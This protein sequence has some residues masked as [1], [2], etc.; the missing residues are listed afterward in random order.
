MRIVCFPNS[1][2]VYSPNRP[3]ERGFVCPEGYSKAILD[4]LPKRA[5]KTAGEQ[6]SSHEIMK[7]FLH[8]LKLVWIVT[9]MFCMIFWTANEK[10]DPMLL[11]HSEHSCTS[12]HVG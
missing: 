6:M 11:P 12:Q 2:V 7:Q 1:A 3:N 9:E 10:A 8:K 5:R 4:Q